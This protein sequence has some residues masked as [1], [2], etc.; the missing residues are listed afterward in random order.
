[1]NEIHYE[2]TGYIVR[3]EDCVGTALGD[4]Q[5]GAILLRGKGAAGQEE[6]IAVEHIPFGH[7]FA[8]KNIAQGG[9]II[10]YGAVIAIAASN[11]RIGEHVHLH[12]VRSNFDMRAATFD[13]KTADSTDMDYQLY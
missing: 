4:I 13:Q 12:N 1:M 10:K 11:I 6:V 3:K 2:Q 5:E 9:P 7:K 8:V